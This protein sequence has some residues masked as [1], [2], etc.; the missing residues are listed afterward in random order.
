MKEVYYQILHHI[1]QHLVAWVLV[2]VI[3]IRNLPGKASIK[4]AIP[5]TF[6][7]LICYMVIGTMHGVKIFNEK[8]FWGLLGYIGL[9][10][11]VFT[12][13]QFTSIADKVQGFLKLVQPG[14]TS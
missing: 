10:T 5:A 14:T 13:M 6:T 8:A 2:S 12:V 11:S 3:A 9:A 1:S 4:R 7:L